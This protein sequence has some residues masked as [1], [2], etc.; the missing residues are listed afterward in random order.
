MK[1]GILIVEDEFIVAN[2]LATILRK[3]GYKVCGIADSV[4][5]ALKLVESQ[6]PD[7]VLLD[8]VLRGNLTGID[9]AKLLREQY[10]PFIY[11]SANSNSSVLQEAKS[12]RPY[13]FLVKPFRERDV[14]IA[15]EIAFY[16]HQHSRDYNAHQE[17]T[18]Y[19]RLNEILDKSSNSPNGLL[20]LVQ[21]LQTILPFDYMHLVSGGSDRLP[22]HYEGFQRVGFKEY[23]RLGIDEISNITNRNSQELL[24]EFSESL[25]LEIPL[26]YSDEKIKELK[27]GES[28]EAMI[29]KTF[30]LRS[31]IYFPLIIDEQRTLSVT[32]YSRQ[33]QVYVSEHLEQLIRSKS[34]I[35]DVIRKF[36][37]SRN[38][39]SFTSRKQTSTPQI[40]SGFDQMIGKSPLLLNVFDLIKKVSPLDTSVLILGDSGT[41]KEL[42]AR[43]IHR[44]SKRKDK[45]FVVINCATLPENLIES[46]LFGHEKGSFTGAMEKKVGKFEQA[47]HGTIFLDEIGEMPHNLQVK[48]LRVLQEKEIERIGANMPIT[49]DVRIIAATNRNLEEE[50]EAGRFRLDLYYRLFVYPISLPSL[51]ERKEDIPMLVDHFIKK[52]S[53]EGST[54]DISKRAL[55][56]IMNRTWNGNIRELEHFIERNVLLAKDGVIDELSY[57]QKYT[58]ETPVMEEKKDHRLKSLVDFERDHILSVLKDCRGKVFGAGGA[59]EILKIP[60]STLNSKIK[61]LGITK[62]EIYSQE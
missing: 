25:P 49:L 28:F 1:N 15:L 24:Q 2:D 30:Q 12:T 57:L 16:H 11:I 44:N 62:G 14:L 45:P 5:E 35:V 56:E 46:I 13:G 47:N 61:K 32:F 52:Y 38:N 51:K 23:Q 10:I 58:L 55:N 54:P 43:S 20:S 33:E 17:L 36:I 39:V 27:M 60:T 29:T 18:L 40:T 34:L 59:A 4:K 42:V 26:I 21:A 48:L 22:L 50:V 41:G 19:N 6:S 7:M 8:I 3:A 53:P 37:P 31:L 9:L